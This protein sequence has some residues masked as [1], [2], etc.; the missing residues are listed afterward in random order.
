VVV[1]LSGAIGSGK[2]TVGR[3]LASRGAKVID[4]DQVAREVLAPGSDAERAVLKRFGPAIVQGDGGLDRRALAA[5]VF[6]DAGARKDL[7][8]ITHPLILRSV[9]GAVAASTANVL[10]VELP[11]L[12]LDRRRQYGF[13]VVVLVDVTNE[14][15]VSRAVGRGMTESEARA[16]M[17]AQPSRSQRLEAADWVLDNNGDLA[18]LEEQVERLWRH[19]SRSVSRGGIGS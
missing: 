13:D 9:Q 15:A 19:V 16:R 6:A 11:L 5:V 18:H 10:V 8:A 2:S 7:E 1:G 17:Y 4:A 3:A 14:L 12:D